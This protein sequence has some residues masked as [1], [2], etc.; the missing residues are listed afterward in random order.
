MNTLHPSCHLGWRWWN[1][2]LCSVFRWLQSWWSCPYT[3]LSVSTSRTCYNFAQGITF[4]DNAHCSFPYVKQKSWIHYYRAKS[5]HVLTQKLIAR[6]SPG[7]LCSPISVTFWVILSFRF[8]FLVANL[9]SSSWGRILRLKPKKS[10]SWWQSMAL[11]MEWTWMNF[12]M[13]HWYEPIGV[14][15]LLL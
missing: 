7:I 10:L 5:A 8:D 11:K 6:K 9:F 2:Q 14:C 1:R 3:S 4:L 13:L 15:K 12:K